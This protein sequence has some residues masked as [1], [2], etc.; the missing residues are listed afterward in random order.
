M[1]EH[2]ANCRGTDHKDARSHFV[3]RAFDG[4]DFQ[5]LVEDIEVE[6][7]TVLTSRSGRKI[8]LSRAAR[9]VLRSKGYSDSVMSPTV[10]KT[11]KEDKAE[12][13]EYRE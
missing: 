8:Q 2:S 9:A 5:P 13:N 12:G 1:S 3:C 11:V 4:H 7:G 10:V 6:S